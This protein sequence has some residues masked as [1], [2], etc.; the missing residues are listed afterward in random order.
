MS[1]N[2]NKGKNAADSTT[3]SSQ[4]DA[5]STTVTPSSSIDGN[6]GRFRSLSP[7]RARS[8]QG[9][10]STRS[11]DARKPWLDSA[12][13]QEGRRTLER[14]TSTDDNVLYAPTLSPAPSPTRNR[15]SLPSGDD[16]SDTEGNDIFMM[17][18]GS[19][20]RRGS[21]AGM[22]AGAQSFDDLWDES[23]R[24]TGDRSVSVSA[25]INPDPPTPVTG[26]DATSTSKSKKGSRAPPNTPVDGHVVYSTKSSV[27]SPIQE[28]QPQQRKENP[29]KHPRKIA[30]ST[31]KARRSKTKQVRDDSKSENKEDDKPKPVYKDKDEAIV[32]LEK[33]LDRVTFLQK[34]QF[35]QLSS[36]KK[37]LLASRAKEKEHATA[38]EN[39]KTTAEEQKVQIAALEEQLLQNGTSPSV[40]A[41]AAAVGAGTA[42]AVSQI[43]GS[44]SSSSLSDKALQEKDAKIAEL[45][46][47]LNDMKKE[48]EETTDQLGNSLAVTE[49]KLRKKADQ[50]EKQH[51]ELEEMRERLTAANASIEQLE[52]ERNFSQAKMSELNVRISQKGGL[53]DTETELMQR[54]TEISSLSAKLNATDGKIQ[55]RD[56]TIFKLEEE[57]KGVNEL[58]KQLSDAFVS[59]DKELSSHQDLLLESAGSASQ[60]SSLLLMTMMNMLDSMK[61]KM[62][63]LQQERDDASAKASDRGIQLAESHIRVDKLRTEL[64]RMRV[65]RERARTRAEQ[66]LNPN[67]P[68]RGGPPPGAKPRPK[69]GPSQQGQG[70]RWAANGKEGIGRRGS[71]AGAKSSLQTNSERSKVSV[72]TAPP[73]S[74]AAPQKPSRFMSF[75]KGNLT[76]EAAPKGGT[77][78]KGSPNVVQA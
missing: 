37:M 30:G 63:T 73:G 27:D 56:N 41:A 17:N 35:D 71:A 60:T 64:R 74:I 3:S 40:K 11:S 14:K 25:A 57:I 68:R 8:Q 75:I 44:V 43:A 28:D 65:D 69:G 66:P 19:T 70:N 1:R 62:K 15:C 29:I 54:A 24:A 77:C 38:G 52:E 9:R 13:E 20:G 21:T 33:Q 50:Y 10:F 16:D 72:A 36:L 32:S 78:S 46:Q 53:S 47:Q 59:D 4:Q 49:S 76:Q 2:T 5:T 45:E 67:D 42:S 23:V 18:D 61:T 48:K 55:D 22:L 51:E 34:R 39:W 6:E 12:N 26:T 7:T 31:E 58:V